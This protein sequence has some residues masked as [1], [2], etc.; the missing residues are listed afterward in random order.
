[1]VPTPPPT[2]GRDLASL[3][4]PLPPAPPAVSKLSGLGVSESPRLSLLP[5]FDS[6]PAVRPQPPSSVST[7]LPAPVPHH[8]Q[9]PAPHPVSV[10]FST[11]VPPPC[12]LSPSSA[13]GPEPGP[14]RR[15][16][17]RASGR[18]G[19]R[20]LGWAGV[21]RQLFSISRDPAG[22]AP[23]MH[24]AGSSSPPSCGWGDPRDFQIG[25]GGGF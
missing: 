5:V 10:P 23:S 22:S 19:P 24:G 16:G 11:A 18:A 13:P 14:R 9:T 25:L 8:W 12:P 7:P 3:H 6:V 2:A 20:P 15:E 17:V 1:M 21:G 4:G